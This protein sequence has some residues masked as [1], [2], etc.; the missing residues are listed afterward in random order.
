MHPASE[1]LAYTRTGT[2]KK[3]SKVADTGK[4]ITSHFCPD[5]GTTLFR[6][7]ESFP[8]KHLIKVG[9]FDDPEWPNKHI[10]TGELFV[11]ERLAWLLPIKDAVQMDAM[12]GA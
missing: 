7:G 5:C 10:P 9:I 1:F 11:P 2:P 4:N 12:P 3:I 6:T 8:G